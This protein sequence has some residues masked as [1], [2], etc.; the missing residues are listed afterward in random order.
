MESSKDPEDW[1]DPPE[2]PDVI[3][4][5]QKLPTVKSIENLT[6]KE[7]IENLFMVETKSPINGQ[8]IVPF[9][10]NDVQNELDA[11]GLEDRFHLILKARQLG[12]STYV[13]ARFLAKCLTVEGTHAAVVS[14]ER[15]ATARLLRKVHFFL[16]NMPGG[17][18]VVPREYDNKY[19]L[20]FPR[21]H[22]SFYLGTAGQRSFSRGDMLT[23]FHGSEIAFW[24]D[25]ERLMEGVMGA[26]TPEAEVWLESTANGMG[27]LFYDLV[28]QCLEDRE[29]QKESTYRFHFFEWTKERGYSRNVKVGTVWSPEEDWLMGK[30]NIRPEQL[31]WRRFKKS[32]YKSEETFFQ[33][34]PLTPDEAFIVTGSCYFDKTSL[35]LYQRVVKDPQARGMVELVGDDARL[36]RHPEGRLRV[37]EF[38]KTM[39]EYLITVDCSEGLDDPLSDLTHVEVLNREAFSQAANINGKL[40][41]IETA[42]KVYALGKLYNWPWIAVEDNGP[43]LTCLLKLKELGYPRLYRHRRLNLEDGHESSE[44]LGWHTDGRTRVLALTALRS[45]TRQQSLTIRD[46]ELLKELSTFCRQKDGSYK[47][48]SGCHDDRVMAI[49]IGVYL[50]QI[51]SYEP[52]DTWGGRDVGPRQ[53]FQHG[54]KTG[55]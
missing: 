39:V 53:V 50:H 19:E 49:A 21:T 40:D 1:Q 22:S 38:P 3:P 5:R 54:I 37:W 28:K 32:Q 47:A 18:D 33:E 2:A 10:L 27:G 30:H 31:A 55:Y 20:T 45:A 35:R 43:G 46:Q 24:A 52:L 48:N 9:K 12:C 23:D 36:F 42:L 11:A 14:H 7:V 15:Q 41:P 8:R 29:L 51:L 26:L 17:K 13:E 4:A 34:F 44:K 6:V 25:P 16:D